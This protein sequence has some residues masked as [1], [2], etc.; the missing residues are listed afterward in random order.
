MTKDRQQLRDAARH[1]GRNALGSDE[2]IEVL[3]ANS[4]GNGI[5][6]SHKGWFTACD[7]A[8]LAELYGDEEI[9]QDKGMW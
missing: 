1:I 6:P 8:L 4:S 5:S 3:T 9:H 2:S 7:E